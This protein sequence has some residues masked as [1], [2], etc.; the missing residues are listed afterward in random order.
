MLSLAANLEIYQNCKVVNR[1]NAQNGT[2]E[3]R[4]ETSEGEQSTKLPEFVT[5]GVPIYSGLRAEDGKLKA[6]LIQMR[7]RYRVQNGVVTFRLAP[8]KLDDLL[9]QV[10]TELVAELRKLPVPVI[11]AK[12]P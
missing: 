7:L 1:R 9:D 8:V 11:E 4:F 2:G 5:V 10:W 12:A 6:W 3:I